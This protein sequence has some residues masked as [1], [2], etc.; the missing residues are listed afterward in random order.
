MTEFPVSHKEDTDRDDNSYHI[1][2]YRNPTIHHTHQCKNIPLLN[3]RY[4][5]IEIVVCCVHNNMISL[6]PSNY[7][8]DKVLDD[9]VIHI[10]E[11][12]IYV[13]YTIDHSYEVC[14]ILKSR[15]CVVYHR[16]TNNL[17]VQLCDCFD[18]QDISNQ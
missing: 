11:D 6:V 9:K 14:C 5:H 16:N 13:A 2:A 17:L 18:S 10:R 3:N 1:Y 7:K 4:L 15:G 12:M 8:E